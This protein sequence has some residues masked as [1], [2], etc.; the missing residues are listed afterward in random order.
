MAG[1]KMCSA[2]PMQ[3]LNLIVVPAFY[4][5]YISCLSFHFAVCAVSIEVHISYSLPGL[6][7]ISWRLNFEV[8]DNG[9]AIRCNCPG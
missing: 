8:S 6:A 1:S 3:I 5:L 9:E 7:D 4:S 2:V